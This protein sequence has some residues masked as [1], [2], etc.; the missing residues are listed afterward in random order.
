M[1]TSINITET[2]SNFDHNNFAD[3]NLWKSFGKSIWNV[4]TWAWI[5]VLLLE[6]DAISIRDNIDWYEKCL[7]LT[8]HCNWSLDGMRNEVVEYC[9]VS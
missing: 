4:S 2:K 5:A 1:T 9:P 3:I 8:D 6:N 7:I